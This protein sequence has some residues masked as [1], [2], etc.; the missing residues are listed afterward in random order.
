MVLRRVFVLVVVVA[1]ACGRDRPPPPRD[2]AQGCRA[3]IEAAGQ[4][5]QVS[6]AL[7]EALACERLYRDPACRAAWQA[8]GRDEDHLDD[9][10]EDIEQTCRR[11]CIRDSGGAPRRGCVDPVDRFGD[12][13]VLGRVVELDRALLE[14]AGLTAA[15][16]EALAMRTIVLAARARRGGPAGQVA[17]D[18]DDVPDDVPDDDPDDVD[19]LPGVDATPGMLTVEV[20]IAQIR[21]AGD[22]VA[23]EDLE[24]KV[25]ALRTRLGVTRAE[26]QGRPDVPYERLIAVL[27]AVR[28]AGIDDVSF[29]AGDP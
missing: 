22:V 13:S 6:L 28:A 9:A 8:L 20:E 4:A 16:A 23:L 11:A 12:G 2:A 10:L 25:E 3:A 21:V 19:D 7:R 15:E 17:F 29:S 26:V 27:D 5:G 1:A 14:H 24:D 18:P